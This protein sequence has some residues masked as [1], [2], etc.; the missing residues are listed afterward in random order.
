MVG[1]QGPTF[2]LVRLSVESSSVQSED[3]RDRMAHFSSFALPLTDSQH[4]EEL[5]TP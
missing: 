5:D 2:D 4:E 1:V 3:V